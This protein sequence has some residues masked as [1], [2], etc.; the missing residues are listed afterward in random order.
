[1]H[2]P[3]LFGT[4]TRGEEAVSRTADFLPSTGISKGGA[5]SCTGDVLGILIAVARMT[6]LDVATDCTIEWN[7]IFFRDP[8][9]LPTIEEVVHVGRHLT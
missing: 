6:V 4:T 8:I 2:N 5:I 3:A 1:V 7:D 9:L